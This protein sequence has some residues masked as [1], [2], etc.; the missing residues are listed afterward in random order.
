M[1][2]SNVLQC[3]AEAEKINYSLQYKYERSMPFMDFFNSF[4]KMCLIYK[5]EGEPLANQAK[6]RELLC[7]CSSLP[8]VLYAIL[9]LK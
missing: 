5:E 7:M 8:V 3:I 4:Q 6:V 1:L 2:H 9:A